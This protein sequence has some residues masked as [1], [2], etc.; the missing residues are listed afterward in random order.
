MTLPP[1]WR[2]DTPLLDA[3][4]AAVIGTDLTGTIFYCNATAEALYGYTQEQLQGSSVMDLLVPTGGMAAAHEIM[5]Q[6]TAGQ[7]WTGEFLVRTAS[8]A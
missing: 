2:S 5:R 4:G 8:G 7:R 3:L 6:V 1:S